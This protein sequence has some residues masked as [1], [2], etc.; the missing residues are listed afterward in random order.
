M[1]VLRSLAVLAGALLVGATSVSAQTRPMPVVPGD[2]APPPDTVP[3]APGWPP[4]A[5]L[6]AGFALPAT[7]DA[8]A[9]PRPWEYAVGAGW[10]WD[11][12]IPFLG[13]DGPDDAVL[14]PRAAVSRLFWS[15][16]GQLRATGAGRYTGYPH[17]DQLRRYYA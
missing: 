13:P 2:A 17:E 16:R 12:N 7:G 11:H 6:P 10:G 15:P 4:R 3:P 1:H 8:P 14:I 5:A 9:R